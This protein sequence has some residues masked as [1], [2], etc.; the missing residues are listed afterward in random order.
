MCCWNTPISQL[1]YPTLFPRGENGYHLEM[2]QTHP[3]TGAALRKKVSCMDFYAYSFISR[4]Q[5]SNYILIVVNFSSLK[6]TQLHSLQSKL[7]VEKYV[8][9]EN[10]IANDEELAR[11]GQTGYSFYFVYWKSNTHARIYSG[12]FE[13]Y[14]QL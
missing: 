1:Q 6:R 8:D 14:S 7:S 9:L 3:V 10:T 11:V 4:N 5:Q 13:I 12:C 2:Y